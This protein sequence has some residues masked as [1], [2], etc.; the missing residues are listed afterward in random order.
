MKRG[1]T[2]IELAVGAVLGLMLL[3]L[4]QTRFEAQRNLSLVTDAQR[5][6]TRLAEAM[7]AY[8]VDNGSYPASYHHSWVLPKK[9][10]VAVDVRLLTT[11]L[12]YL[13][14]VPDDPFRVAAGQSQP[15]Y[16]PYGVSYRLNDTARY[17]TYPRTAWMS[18]SIGPDRLSIPGGYRAYSELI[19]NESQPKPDLAKGMRYDP[20]NG[21]LSYGD[22]F[23]FGGEAVSR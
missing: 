19:D 3:L 23:L 2:L 20:T 13:P 1:M 5:S 12:P 10:L 7:E 18:W 14:R 6:M 9:T 15:W 4:V 11:P 8:L 22:I 16:F 21:G 17:S